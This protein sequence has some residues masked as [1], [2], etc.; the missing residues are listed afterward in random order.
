MQLANQEAERFNH[1]FIDAGHILVGLAKEGVGL[2][3]CVL[4]NAGV[5]LREIREEIEKVMPIGHDVVVMG[6]TP[7][8]PRA[9]KAIEA[10]MEESVALNHSYV[11]TEH[12]L[13]G[14]L[15]ETDGVSAAVMS[16]L[17]IN[18]KMLR[19]E[20][21]RLLGNKTKGTPPA[22]TTKSLT[23]ADY[24][25]ALEPFSDTDEIVED[26]LLSISTG[27]LF[28]RFAKA[29]QPVASNGEPQT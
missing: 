11:G 28:I 18:Q 23:K 1:E 17:G 2:A 24:L 22:P 20:V 5:S 3:A 13:L 21:L 4:E 19:A 29:R 27:Q 12:L 9:R 7:Q 26:I 15:R 16:R 10:A 8:T 6:K 25:K 14:I